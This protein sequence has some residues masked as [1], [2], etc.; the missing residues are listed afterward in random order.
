MTD[1]RTAACVMLT[2]DAGVSPRQFAQLALRVET[3]EDLWTVDPE[4]YRKAGGLNATQ[5]KKWAR[6]Q[7]RQ[8]DILA[9][10]AAHEEGG[11]DSVSCFDA[12]YYPRL[13]KLT[14]PGTP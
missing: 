12:S 7:K 1:V 14:N 11:L 5:T 4:A 10:L 3:P 2:E 9:R 8:A 6:A 13:L